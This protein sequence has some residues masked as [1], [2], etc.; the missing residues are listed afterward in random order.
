MDKHIYWRGE[1][2]AAHHL[3]LNYE[4]KCS[5]THG[6]NY[7]VEVWI[8]GELNENGM[9]MDFSDIKDVVYRYDHKDLNNLLENPTAENIAIDILEGLRSP[10][11]WRLRVR[12]WEDRDSY[13]E[14]EWMP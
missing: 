12:V 9:I 1:V 13:A 8:Y 7:L 14:A 4:S 10:N 3:N 6:H 5:K 2:S 11:L